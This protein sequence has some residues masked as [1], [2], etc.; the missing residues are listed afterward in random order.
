[1][2]A[3]AA[4]AGTSDADPSAQSVQHVLKGYTKSV[5]SYQ[6]STRQVAGNGLEASVPRS[7]AVAI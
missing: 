5:A 3:L 7:D 2:A 6:D 1:M 4:W